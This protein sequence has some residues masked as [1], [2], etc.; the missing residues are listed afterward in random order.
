MK[1]TTSIHNCFRVYRNIINNGKKLNSLKRHAM[2]VSSNEQMAF[3][4]SNKYFSTTKRFQH[5][6]SS[7]PGS[8]S[9]WLR[10]LLTSG[11]VYSGINY[12][13]SSNDNNRSNVVEAA[14]NANKVF[15]RAEVAKH[16]TQKDGI[17]V[18]YKNV[19]YDITDFVEQ[20]P[21][22]EQRIMLAAGGS[23][24]PFWNLYRQHF[25]NKQVQEHL[26]KYQIGVLSDKEE[27]I[28]YDTSDPYASDPKR[29]AALLV[30]NEKP[31]NAETPVSLISN[32]TYITP[33][34]LWYVR[35]HHPVP[36]VEP[37][38]Y[39]LVIEGKGI[40]SPVSLTLDDLKT[41]FKKR[42]VVATMQCGGNRRGAYNEIEKTSGLA[43]QTG[44]IS[45][46]VWGGVLLRDVLEFAGVN[47][48]DA[49]D[50]HGIE[51]VHMYP[52][53]PPYDASIP[54]EKATH[55]RGDVLLAYEMNGT[56]LP[57]EHGYPLRSV[58]PGHIGAR[59]V[60]WLTKIVTSE[61]ESPSVWQQNVQY[62]GFSPNVK[63]FKN[64]DPSKVLSCQEM[65]VQSA[66]VEPGNSSYTISIDDD[67][68]DLSGYA[69]SGGGRPIVRVD[70]SAD[71]GKTWVTAE[72][73]KG[74]E[75]KRGRAWA[76]TLWKATIPLTAELKKLGKENGKIQL[77]CKAVDGSYNQQPENAH[78]LWNRRGILNNSW[79]RVDVPF[80][81][82]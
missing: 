56:E 30:H 26:Q 58:V 69:W 8:S 23:V 17:W 38:E 16:K 6:R 31:F 28:V 70:V 40:T 72:L 47:V 80:D 50:E 62:K 67:D 33:N 25:G 35:H 39:R 76:W 63:S 79:H 57:R 5:N 74:S 59:Q 45:T 19:V 4:R 77:V 2:L 15:S 78:T 14:G 36:V 13:L 44:A 54:V 29:H 49:E 10:A 21:G 71:N 81:S 66:I 1:S 34:E 75:Q 27:K 7:S 37:K 22:G 68:I 46:A 73:G 42:T 60:K 43:W 41:L 52:L 20:H 82:D 11:V 51:H 55:K 18:T 64:V 32:D 24:E 53:D 9:Y 12:T 3:K 65:P 61:Q 48:D